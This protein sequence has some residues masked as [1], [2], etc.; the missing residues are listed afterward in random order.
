MTMPFCYNN[1]QKE[2]I[3][4]KISATH[5]DLNSRKILLQKLQRVLELSGEKLLP[6]NI[7]R[8]NGKICIF[9]KISKTYR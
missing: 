8:N 2:K 5:I 4:L 7:N 9:Q 3:L 1:E 6:P